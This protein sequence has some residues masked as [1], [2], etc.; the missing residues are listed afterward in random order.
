MKSFKEVICEEKRKVSAGVA[1]YT[2]DQI[3]LVQPTGHKRWGIPKGGIEVGE[4]SLEAA[5]RE[6]QEET[7]IALSNTN[8]DDYINIGKYD[9]SSKYGKKD[10]IVY[11][12]KGSGKETYKGSNV[13]LK[14]ERMGMTENCD[15]KYWKLDDALKIVHRGQENIITT[16]KEMIS[17]TV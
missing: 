8:E 17:N 5:M 4:D 2:D 14:G 10:V 6:F 9:I 16:L 1:L 12:L 11:A 13:I 3:F 15:G 7:G